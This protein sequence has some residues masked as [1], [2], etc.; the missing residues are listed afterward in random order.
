MR[1][2]VWV[3][4]WGSLVR[5]FMLILGVN[6][7]VWSLPG[8]ALAGSAHFSFPAGLNV[9]FSLKGSGGYAISLGGSQDQ[10][11]LTASRGHAWASYSTSGLASPRRIKARFGRFGRVS[12]RFRSD[13]KPRLEPFPFDYCRGRRTSVERGVFQGWLGFRGEK[14]YTTVHAFRAK[15]TV[16]R[17]FKQTC[18]QELDEAGDQRNPV[19]TS[20]TAVSRP[21]GVFFTASKVEDK[22]RP[23]LNRP[24]FT[25]SIFESQRKGALSVLRGI[26]ALGNANSFVTTKQ[27]RRIASAMV[28]PPAPF[29]GTATF[30][31]GGSPANWNGTLTGE[32][33]GLGTVSLAGPEF[34]VDPSQAWVASFIVLEDP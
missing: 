2:G 11:W 3:G 7:I 20:L 18:N 15:G 32:F 12:M 4:L 24:I 33:P 26:S 16:T 19:S 23:K 29:D 5:G 6:L 17:S 13:G 31:D 1:K 28:A 22:A 25:A 21:D 14:G 9:E 27:N 34:H 8:A 30:D 10:V